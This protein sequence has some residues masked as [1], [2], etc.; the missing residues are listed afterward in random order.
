MTNETVYIDF[1]LPT[2]DQHIHVFTNDFIFV[3]NLQG[4]KNELIS[5]MYSADMDMENKKMLYEGY[6]F[7]TH[8]RTK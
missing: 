6:P 2:I 4:R 5:D 7:L 1:N 3:F 8:H